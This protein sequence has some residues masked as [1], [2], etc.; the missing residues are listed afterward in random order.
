[1]YLVISKLKIM[2]LQYYL[3]LTVFLFIST[4]AI[5]KG[6]SGNWKEVH[7]ST[8]AT[9]SALSFKDTIIIS[10]LEGNEYIWMSHGSSGNRG[11]YKLLGKKIDFGTRVFSVLESTSRSL[12]LSDGKTT[13]RFAPTTILSEIATSERASE[14]VRS[15][16]DIMG[17]WKVFKRTSDAPL[18][19]VDYHTLL[20]TVYI[21]NTESPYG[22]I[23]AAALPQE[24]DGWKI[25]SM[26]D[27]KL[28]TEGTT[29]RTFEISIRGDELILKEKGIT[30]FLK[31]FDQ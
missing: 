24:K 6:F 26:S 30:Y 13:H 14:P 25:V 17:K 19:K 3:L 8:N 2:K 31:K 23:T 15:L 27:G 1:M 28:F 21:H 12:I 20:Q 9:E 5:S 11:T 29:N 4:A 22:Y 18:G 16:A 10:F 7:R